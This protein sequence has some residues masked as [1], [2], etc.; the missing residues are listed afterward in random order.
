M[1]SNIF[2][3]SKEGKGQKKKERKNIIKKENK[4]KGT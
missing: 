2:L 4:R 3:G 1:S